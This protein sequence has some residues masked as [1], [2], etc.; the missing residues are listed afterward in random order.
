MIMKPTPNIATEIQKIMLW[1]KKTSNP[2][3]MFKIK[4]GMAMGNESK[5]RINHV[6]YT[7]E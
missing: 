6:R 7:P 3:V 2:Y 4:V 5:Y 1:K